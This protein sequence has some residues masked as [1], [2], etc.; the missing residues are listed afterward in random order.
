MNT[1][2]P[3]T[4][5]RQRLLKRVALLALLGGVAAA[6]GIG[7]IAH[8]AGGF[9]WHHPPAMT[10]EDFSA[11]LDKFL[12]HV[13]IEI[14]ATDAQKAQLDPLIRQA[15]A[16]LMPLHAHV[17]DFHKQALT[18]LTQDTVDRAA[19]EN[20]RAEHMRAADDAS[21]RIAQLLGDVAEVLTPA[22]RKALAARVAEVHGG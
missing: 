6:A 22:Q 1:P 5:L 15:A 16:D 18:L 21:R 20:M 17:Q 3:T 11:H 12:Q 14:D 9:G 4:T 10:A 7:A 19:I 2:A 13:Y 8:E